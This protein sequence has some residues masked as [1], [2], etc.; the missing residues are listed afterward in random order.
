MVRERVQH[1][2]GFGGGRSIEIHDAT[3]NVTPVGLL[4][5]SPIGS[6]YFIMHNV[7]PQNS[8]L[9]EPAGLRETIMAQRRIDLIFA[10]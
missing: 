8:T 1:F 3:K 6:A 10:I 5:N 2:Y 7:E 4:G 9:V